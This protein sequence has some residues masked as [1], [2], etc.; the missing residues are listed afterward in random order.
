MALKVTEGHFPLQAFSR[1]IFCICGMLPGPSAS[2]ELLV[3]IG[4]RSPMGRGKFWGKSDT[5]M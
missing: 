2:A 3:S 4:W 5:V 1:A